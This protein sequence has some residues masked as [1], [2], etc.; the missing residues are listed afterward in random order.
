VFFRLDVVIDQ[1]RGVIAE[2]SRLFLRL[3][4]LIAVE[5][6]HLALQRERISGSSA[7]V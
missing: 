6:E 7:L 1:A 5:V 2:L 3:D 4:A